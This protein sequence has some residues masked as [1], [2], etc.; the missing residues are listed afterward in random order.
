MNLPNSISLARLV[1]VFVIV[2]L[3]YIDRHE[4]VAAAFV[5]FCI[6]TISDFIDGYLARK[7]NQITSLGIYIDSLADKF[8][9]L[10]MVIMFVEQFL[11]PA[12]FAILILF[13]EITVTSF[14]DL[15]LRKGV[16]LPAEKIG[17]V[18]AVF[19]FA[20][21][22]CGLL[23]LFFQKSSMLEAFVPLW[24]QACILLLAVATV[25]AYVSMGRIMI[26][27]WRDVV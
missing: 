23:V 19:Q 7:Y 5:L 8:L 13:R 6:A 15:A 12:W 16:S 4:T 22:A 14:R 10:F 25:L 21:V 11:I 2:G 3:V 24:T 27:K 26:T 9:V 1:S 20:G 18:K 17:K